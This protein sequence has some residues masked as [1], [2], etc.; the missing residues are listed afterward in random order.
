MFSR[1]RRA[2]TTSEDGT[3]L[4]YE[5]IGD[6]PETVMLANGLGG[7]LYSWLPLLD[8]FSDRLRLISW[9]YRGL[10]ESASPSDPGA[11]GVP[12][13]AAD[14]RAILRAEG[15]DRAHFVGWS[16]GVQ[17]SL[18]VASRHPEMVQSLVLINGTYGQVFSTAW[19][20]LVRLPI[21]HT[22]WHRGLESIIERPRAMAALRTVARTPAEL[23][24]AV[25]KRLLPGRPSVRTL[26]LRQYA[27]DVTVTNTA[28]YLRLFQEL[29]AHSVYHRLPR[30]AQPTTVIAG[31]YD[32]LTPA[33]QSRQIAA[34]IPDAQ[35]HIL[36]GTHFV[37]MERPALVV[38][39]LERHL[40]RVA[41][42]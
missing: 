29:D 38:E 36:H 34:R 32:P 23:A 7:R 37:L 13:H 8:A 17:V 28:N 9:D 19:Q 27:R 22:L 31:R 40:R 11:L 2:E 30:I 16:M 10:F 4:V 5:V 18:E 41:A 42:L 24:F 12:S 33:Y 6:G 1:L 20:P 39:L 26:G 35:L 3:R 25:R 14:A 21:P 15:L